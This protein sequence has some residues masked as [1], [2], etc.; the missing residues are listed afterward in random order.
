MRHLQASLLCDA[1]AILGEGPVW[2]DNA[3]WFVD[4]EGMR[5]HRLDVGR[6]A[7]ES[8]QLTERVGCAV[9]CGNGRFLAG[10]QSGLHWIDWPVGTATSMASPEKHLPTN[11]FNDGKCDPSGRLLAGTM[12]MK[13]D[14]R[15]G[16]LYV[17]DLDGSVRPLVANV[18]ISNGLEWSPDG[19]TLYYID[20]PTRTIDA[21]DYSPKH[22]ELSNR[23][24]ILTIPTEQGW[25][26]G[27]CSDAE[28]NLW[29]AFWN[30]SAV[31]CYNPNTGEQLAVVEVPASNVTSCCF[32][33]WGLKELY[34][35]TARGGRPEDAE[36]FSHAGGVFYCK[37]GVV[38]RPVNLCKI[39][40][41]G[42]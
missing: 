9:P 22:A 1:H 24:T 32:G 35:T 34:I 25:P 5:L 18:T 11:R 38:G 2:H 23:R 42:V 14:K 29:I 33:G 7:L 40:G 28:G 37:P 10:L 13:G 20:T 30:G 21:F 3:L 16:T 41:E 39:R 19:R 6:T 36:R 4:I 26:D 27:M 15:A 17:V 31:R 12:S 8:V